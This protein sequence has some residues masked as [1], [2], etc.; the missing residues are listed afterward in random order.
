MYRFFL[1][2]LIWGFKAFSSSGFFYFFIFLSF[3][4]CTHVLLWGFFFWEKIEAYDIRIPSTFNFSLGSFKSIILGRLPSL[5]LVI[6]EKKKGN[7]SGIFGLYFEVAV[8][9]SMYCSSVE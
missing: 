8:T 1:I 9:V 3:L 2:Y 5:L 6:L 4:V 7:K